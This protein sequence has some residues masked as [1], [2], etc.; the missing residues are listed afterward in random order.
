[1]EFNSASFLRLT[2][3]ERI[4]K[5]RSFAAEAQRMARAAD[6]EAS[7]GYFGLAKKWSELADEMEAMANEP[8]QTGKHESTR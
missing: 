5:C 7:D 6:G 1:M 3:K 4:A 2:E 8:A